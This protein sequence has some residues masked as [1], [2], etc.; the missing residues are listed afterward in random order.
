MVDNNQRTLYTLETRNLE[1]CQLRS[2]RALRKTTPCWSS[3]LVT[4]GVLLFIITSESV[5]GQACVMCKTSIAASQASIVQSLNLGIVALLLP[6][7]GIFSG[8]LILAFRRD[9]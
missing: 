2:T 5:F 9:E 7:L 3:S 6:P 1:E 4:L 8:I